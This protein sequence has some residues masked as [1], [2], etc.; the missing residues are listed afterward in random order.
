MID[1]NVYFATLPTDEIGSRIMEEVDKYYTYLISTHRLDLWR[2]TYHQF[3]KGYYNK[4][5][6]L[7]TGASGEKRFLSVNHFRNILKHLHVMITQQRPVFEARAINS[8]YESAA[9]VILAQ[10]LLEYYLRQH[11]LEKN[12][13]EAVDRALLYGEG[14]IGWEWN[15]KIGANVTKKDPTEEELKTWRDK[16]GLDEDFGEIPKEISDDMPRSKIIKSGDF[17]FF[18]ISPIDLIRDVTK[19]N[20]EDHQWFIVRRITNKFELADK[21]PDFRK[22]I[23]DVSPKDR[24]YREHWGVEEETWRYE[25]DEIPLY[26]FLHERTV[27]MP[28][29]RLV[30]MVDKDVIMFDGDLPYSDLPLVS[31]VPDV[32]KETPFGYTIAFDMLP[33]QQSLDTLYSSI[34]TNQAAF[35]VQNIVI[36]KGSGIDV[37]SIA[38]GMNLIEVH[39]GKIPQPLNLTKTPQEI[40]TY[41]D[42]LESYMESLAGINQITRGQPQFK[43]SG[44]GMALLQSMAIQFN[45][46]LQNS[47]IAMLE[48]MGTRIINTLKEYASVPRMVKIT[49]KS[50]RPFMKEFTGKDLDKIDKTII[51]VGN[52]VARTVAGRS[53]IAFT[54]LQAGMIKEPSQYIQVLNTGRL[55]PVIESQTAEL[56]NIRSENEKLADGEPVI[57]V[58][59]DDH[60]L[61]I[62]EHKTVMSSP[63]TRQNTQLIQVTLDHIQQHVTLLS[64]PDPNVQKVL[65]ITGQESL[66]VP[67]E[68][69]E[70]PGK[71]PTEEKEVEQPKQP[72]MPENA[73]TGREFDVQTGGL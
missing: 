35:G 10:G 11:R 34:L 51:D 72:S 49:G 63:E 26:T 39:Q 24:G 54:L 14:W 33:V 62:S 29:G 1:H 16:H 6:V 42:M 32:Q 3:Y 12:I 9:Q 66:Y 43:M 19:K 61:H 47:Y 22:K 15:P 52:P 4:A 31:I 46:G 58:L 25:T 28:N 41:I 50:N 38:G 7:R 69:K 20:L 45:S 13:N 5:E 64:S 56:M 67:P 48:D 55:E 21:Y 37:T 70:A 8:D 68:T 73:L 17:D 44:S 36:E 27:A 30:E 23:I 18:T 40:F 60:R 53:E 71:V 65:L 59:T 2:K 57:A